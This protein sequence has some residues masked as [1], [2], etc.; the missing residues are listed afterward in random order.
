M[1]R[2]FKN[3]R[4]TLIARGAITRESAPSYFLEGLLFN[5]PNDKFGTS[6]GDTFVAS[7]NWMLQTDRS[8]LMCANRQLPLILDYRAECWP[9]ANCDGFINSLVDLWNKWS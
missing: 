2:I 8:K 7:V 1:V 9:R 3:M 5:V 4:G 6:Y